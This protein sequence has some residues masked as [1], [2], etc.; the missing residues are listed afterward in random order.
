MK[1]FLVSR[2]D[3]IGYEEYD[4]F[5]CAAESEEQALRM[6]PDD[7]WRTREYVNG[8]IIWEW[9]KDLNKIKVEYIGEAD[10]KYTKPA[11]IL[12]SFNAG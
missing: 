10:E 9:T 4:A 11:V 3:D 2:T 12:A 7:D 6:L 5:V 8:L 1:L